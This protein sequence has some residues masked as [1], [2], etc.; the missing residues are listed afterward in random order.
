[1]KIPTAK[2]LKAQAL[3]LQKTA[4]TDKKAFETISALIKSIGCNIIAT[5]PDIHDK[6]IAYTSQLAHIV[7]SSY[8]KSPSIELERGFTGGSFSGYDKGCL[9]KRRDVEG[10]VYAQQG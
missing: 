6:I 5:T 1:M 2:C 9:I 7:S 4:L 3:Y 8:V 10:F